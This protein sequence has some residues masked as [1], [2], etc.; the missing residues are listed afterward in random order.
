MV[1]LNGKFIEKNQAH[2]S[3]MDRGFLFGDGV[4]EVI[5]VYN[6]KIFRLNAHLL[7]LQ[8]GLDSVKIKNPYNLKEWGDILSKLLGF[9]NNQEQSI[10][11][12]I[13][14]GVSNKR[15]HSFSNLTPTVYIESN[16]LLTKTKQ[17]FKAGFSAITQPDIRWHRCDIK[18]ISLLANVMYSQQ[19]KE[20]N[21]EEVILYRDNQV[22]EGAT[23]NVFIIKDG[24]LFTHPTGVHILSGITRDLVLES[25]RACHIPIKKVSFS[26][27]ELNA[28][29]ELW[30]SSS[31][32]EIMPIT[33]VD[34]KLINRGN[35]GNAWSCVYSYYQSLKNA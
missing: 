13:S 5:P 3:V 26:M 16:P 4:Y 22:T 32:R 15:K 28:A 19:A 24:T 2:I 11:L 9:Y 17:A 25:A 31:T 18:S 35:I 14:R 20:K 23:S 33:Q 34:G 12:Q 30:I 6:N 1:F 21:V 29:D 27:D 7:R 8:T 10:Y